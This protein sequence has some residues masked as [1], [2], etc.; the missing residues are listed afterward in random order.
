MGR[1]QGPADFRLAI[2]T[3]AEPVS[4]NEPISLTLE[5]TYTG[6]GNVVLVAGDLLDVELNPPPGWQLDPIGKVRHVLGPIPE[7]ALST[8]DSFT[9]RIDLRRRFSVLR[10]GRAAIQLTVRLWPLAGPAEQP[11]VLSGEGIFEITS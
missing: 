3:P 11:I 7:V 10:P 6:A 9:H 1:D 4:V 2:S 8:G 5:I